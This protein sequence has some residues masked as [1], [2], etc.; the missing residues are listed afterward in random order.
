MQQ[1]DERLDVGLVVPDDSARP[2]KTMLAA[3]DVEE[4]DVLPDLAA[5]L[6][7][8]QPVDEPVAIFGRLVE[9][10][11]E[12][13]VVPELRL[14][15]EQHA[16]PFRV[17]ARHRA[18]CLV[19]PLLDDQIDVAPVLLD[20]ELN[21]EVALAAEVVE[22]RAAREPGRLLEPRDGRPGIAVLREGA[23]GAVEDLRA[24]PLEMG[25]GDLGHDPHFTKPYGRF[26]IST[27]SGT[28]RSSG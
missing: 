24:A 21:E 25:L 10:P 16:E 19:E 20:R 11:D 3:A 6:R 27:C 1:L 7:F 17:S 5:S 2:F 18:N 22:D 9:L 26:I 15:L 14:D 8:A 23:A 4:V 28:A 12:L 13:R